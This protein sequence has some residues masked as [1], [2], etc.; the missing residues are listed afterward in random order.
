MAIYCAQNEKFQLLGISIMVGALNLYS[1]TIKFVWTVLLLERADFDSLLIPSAQRYNRIW[2]TFSKCDC[3]VCVVYLDG[4]QALINR[5]YNIIAEIVVRMCQKSS[6]IRPL[7]H[8]PPSEAA[9]LWKIICL[10]NGRTHRYL[11]HNLFHRNFKFGPP[12]LEDPL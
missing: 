5:H 7:V 2:Q 6:K 1:Y 4:Q 9:M 8:L 11:T 3:V 10:S 12:L